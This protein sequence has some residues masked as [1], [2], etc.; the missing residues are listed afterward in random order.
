MFWYIYG[1]VIVICHVPIVVD[2]VR[3]VRPQLKIPRVT[4]TASRFLL[5]FLAG[6]VFCVAILQ[7][8]TVFLPLVAPEPLHRSLYSV[9]HVVVSGWMWINVTVHFFSALFVHP[10]EVRQLPSTVSDAENDKGLWNENMGNGL[11]YRNRG[12]QTEE[13]ELDLPVCGTE[14]YNNSACKLES[15]MEWSP[16]R[17]NYCRACGVNVAYADHHCPYIGKCLGINNYA[18][19]YI[20]MVYSL[21]GMLYA[22][23]VTLPYFYKCDIRW[24]LGW[25]LTMD[26]EHVCEVLGTQS[27]TSIPIFVA[28]WLCFNMVLIQTILLM[29]DISTF[30]LLKNAQRVPLLKFT[31]ERIKGRKFL[32]PN[33]R[34]NVLI[35]NQRPNALYYV[36]PLRNRSI[37]NIRQPVSIL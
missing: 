31:W 8:Y 19:F 32:Q 16:I 37:H 35:R 9:L 15:G 7:L 24:L 11:T 20:G 27:R 28:L 4:G 1:S 14:S 5:V 10:G 2:V 23:C 29:A 33:S 34:F 3:L 25:S 36:F 17:S 13:S 18:H 30:N 26:D 22:L 6:V 12:N 21:L